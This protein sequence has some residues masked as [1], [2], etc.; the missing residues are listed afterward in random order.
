MKKVPWLAVPLLAVFLLALLNFVQD[1]IRWKQD[2]TEEIKQKLN[3]MV[4]GVRTKDLNRVFQHISEDFKRKGA[5]KENFRQN[6]ESAIGLLQ[7]SEICITDPDVGVDLAK[8]TAQAE[9]LVMKRE[10]GAGFARCQTEFTRDA[11]RQWRVSTI[12]IYYGGHELRL[13]F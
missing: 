6:V 8:G 3:E 9:F 2:P 7:T 10:N 13:P 5:N 1:L 12:E 11:D 4:E